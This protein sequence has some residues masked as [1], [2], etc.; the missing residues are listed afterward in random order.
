MI[1]FSI[2]SL[3]WHSTHDVRPPTLTSSLL[4]M[5]CL[6]LYIFFPP[7]TPDYLL[8]TTTGRQLIEMFDSSPTF[9]SL[10]LFFSF[11]SKNFFLS[12]IHST[13]AR[14]NIFR[15]LRRKFYTWLMFFFQMRRVWRILF[16]LS[17]FQIT[18]NAKEINSIAT[19]AIEFF[20]I[21]KKNI[22]VSFH[23]FSRSP[24]DERHFFAI[25]MST[26]TEILRR[27]WI[28]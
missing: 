27:R 11:L 26:C 4:S 22:F 14:N 10:R 5:Y 13:D 12:T 1:F 21:M 7:T 19:S 17:C 28:N 6:T 15:I 18:V 24:N 23:G 3:W 16:S 25:L 20:F 9:T 8:V 2:D